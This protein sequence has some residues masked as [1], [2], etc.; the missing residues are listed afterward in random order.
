[1]DPLV[2][3][4]NRAGSTKGTELAALHIA[5]QKAQAFVRKFFVVCLGFLAIDV[6]QK[7]IVGF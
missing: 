1:M 3:E 5:E 4:Y 7:M 2:D 6:V